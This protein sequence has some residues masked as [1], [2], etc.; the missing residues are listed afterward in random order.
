MAKKASDYIPFCK[1]QGIPHLTGAGAGGSSMQFKNN[2]A[3][4]GGG[5]FVFEDQGLVNM[6][7]GNYVVLTQNQTD[8]LDPGT[9]GSKT[10]TGFVLTGPDAA[11]EID[12]VIIGRLDGQSAAS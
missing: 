12:I 2:W 4:P 3:M 8:V 1:D 10:K 9:V 11:D 7:D 6:S 5:A